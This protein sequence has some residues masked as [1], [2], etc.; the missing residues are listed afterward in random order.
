MLRWLF[1]LVLIVGC[2]QTVTETVTRSPR[3]NSFTAGVCKKD[4][5][6]P[7]YHVCRSG[8]CYGQ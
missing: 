2:G 6:C 5:D 1:A 7:P 4:S 8:R 3:E